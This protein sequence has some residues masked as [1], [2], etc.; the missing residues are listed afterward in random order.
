MY[1]YKQNNSS[2]EGDNMEGIIYLE[3]GSYFRGV[4]FGAETTKVG[5]LVFNT[6]M[7]GYQAILTDPSYKGQ[8]INMSYPLI[9]NYGISEDDSQSEKIHAFGLITRDITFHPSDKKSIMNINDWL[10]KEGVPGVFYVDT[11]SIT[12]KIRNEGTIKCVIST[13]GIS[14]EKAAE[15]LQSSELRCDYM[16]EVGTKETLH[17]P[18]NGPKVAILDFG[19][20]SNIVKSFTNRDCDVWIFPYGTSA[21]EILATRPDGLFLSNG[22][23]DPEA[24]IE[25]INTAKELV[26]Q[27]PIFGICMGHQVL[28]LAMGAETYKLKFGHRGGNHGV[29]DKE[30]DKSAI[31]SQ[32]HSFAISPESIEKSDMIITHINLNDGTVEGMRHKTLP[33][34]SVQFHP[35]GSPGPNDSD[36]LFDRFFNLI[37]GGKQNA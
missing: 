21:K 22:P 16:K 10:E 17:I 12:K 2:E 31:T 32:N 20:K 19:I 27:L 5:E 36:Y 23:G 8:I 18:G 14:K 34:F 3:G 13:E 15:I 33:I 37:K 24:A 28:G 7:S 35:E 1:N 4:G 25:G 9:G 6:C 26:G 29:Y 11:R 30:T